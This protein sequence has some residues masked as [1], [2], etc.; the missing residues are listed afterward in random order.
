VK[1]NIQFSNNDIYIH[2]NLFTTSD[3]TGKLIQVDSKGQIDKTKLPVGESNDVV[4]TSKTL[5]SFF[6]NKLRIK[7]KTVE[8]DFGSYS[9][10]E[11]FLIRNKIY[12]AIT[13]ID[14]QK[15][16]LY[17]SNAKSIPGFPAFGSSAIDLENFDKDPKLEFVTKG[18][19]NTILVYKLN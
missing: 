6:E 15:V 1:E 2:N 9:K 14:A 16:Y 5:V 3:R 17:D 18:E 10:P 4:M 7:D 12:V 11:I 19:K 13:D 8:L